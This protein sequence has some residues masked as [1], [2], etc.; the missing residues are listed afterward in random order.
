MNRELTFGEENDI[1]D[2]FFGRVKILDRAK[3][4]KRKVIERLDSM[5]RKDE[6]ADKSD[7]EKGKLIELPEEY[8]M[9]ISAV[10]EKIYIFTRNGMDIE[11]SCHH[12]FD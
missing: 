1:K 4:V 9:I 8:I 10:T 11:Y 7:I 12:Y 5:S 6:D 3:V 2:Y